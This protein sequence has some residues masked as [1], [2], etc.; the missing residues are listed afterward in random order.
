MI[1]SRPGFQIAQILVQ[2][3]DTD[4]Q[5]CKSVVDRGSELRQSTVWGIVGLQEPAGVVGGCFCYALDGHGSLA[6]KVFLRDLEDRRK[7]L[8]R[9]LAKEFLGEGSSMEVL[10]WDCVWHSGIAKG[11]CVYVSPKGDSRR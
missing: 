2:S 7:K 1:R 3:T 8:Y 4:K 10:N 11:Q 5:T 6:G 9:Y